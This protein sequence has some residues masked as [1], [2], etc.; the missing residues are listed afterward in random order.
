MALVDDGYT[1]LADLISAFDEAEQVG[2]H[3]FLKSKPTRRRRDPWH[4]LSMAGNLADEMVET[5]ETTLREI[6]AR[7]ADEDLIE[8]FTFDAMADHDIG[9]LSVADTPGLGQWLEEVPVPDWPQRFQGDEDV[10]ENTRLYVT[11]LS[12]PD[13]R[14]L[15]NF[16]GSRNLNVALRRRNA[17]IAQFRPDADELV[18][19]GGTVVNFDQDVDFFLWEGLVFVRNL[20]T[21]ESVTNIR[22]VTAQKAGE[23]V[24]ALGERFALD[25][26]EGLKEAIGARPLLAKK[27]ASALRHGLVADIDVG[28]LPERIAAKELDIVCEADGEGFRLRIDARD[29]RQVQDFVDLMSD[30]FLHSP[31]TGREWVVSVKKPPRPRRR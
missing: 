18:P 9:V 1:A 12:F 15:L 19:V 31:V 17:V 24:D 22:R 28:A 30:V 16:R 6:A 10:L 21:F 2:C 4:M 8:E 23:A 27:L 5:A 20:R 13:G 3:V 11:R 26:A 7:A 29:R 14:V 25:D